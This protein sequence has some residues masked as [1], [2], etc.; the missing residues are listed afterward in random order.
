V[1]SGDLA[2]AAEAA[3]G[4][5]GVRDATCQ[6]GEID[7]I[8]DEARRLLPSLLEAVT[9]DGVTI[10]SVDVIE[11][12]LESVFLHLTGKALRD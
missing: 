10:K 1:A 6:D 8:V 4:I 2:E 7:L 11:P 5:P 12:D 9:S 3:R